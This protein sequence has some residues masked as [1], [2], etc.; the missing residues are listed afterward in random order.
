MDT[1][2]LERRFRPWRYGIGHSQLLMHSQA[3]ASSDEYINVLF[4]DVRAVK[5]RSS[6]EPLIL[7]QADERTRPGLLGFAQ[8]PPR[9]HPRFLCMTLPTEDAEPGFIVCARATVLSTTSTDSADL[10][11]WTDQSQVL[12]TLRPTETTVPHSINMST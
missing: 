5:L 4:E 9:L 3:N 11:A 1:L 10:Y 2:T 12:H 6:Y 7:Q 8:V